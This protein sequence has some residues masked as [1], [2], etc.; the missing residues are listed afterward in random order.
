[1][2]Y[3]ARSRKEDLL[4]LAE[5]LGL[6][7]KKEF[8]VKQLHKLI[9]ESSSYD[10][11]IT[12]ELL[13]AIKEEREKRRS[14]IVF[15]CKIN[16]KGNID[17]GKRWKKYRFKGNQHIKKDVKIKV[18]TNPNRSASFS[19]LS[20]DESTQL[21]TNDSKNYR[22][23]DISI[24]KEFE[25]SLCCSTCHGKINIIET[26]NYGYSSVFKI[27]KIGRDKK[28]SYYLRRAVFAMRMIGKGAKSLQ[29]FSSYMALPAPIS[30]TPYDKI[31]DEILRATTVVA[32]SCMKKAAQEEEL[33]TLSSDIM[34][35]GDGT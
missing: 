20:V 32:N 9:T 10:E 23:I 28:C 19:K 3:L 34:V 33:L 6:T 24:F 1:M 22:F 5:E 35:S 18:E 7:V 13:G 4:V 21:L 17:S 16:D 2:A 12:R 29:K 30:Q 25:S 27:V 11:E 26:T 31:N 14:F 8:K 15:I